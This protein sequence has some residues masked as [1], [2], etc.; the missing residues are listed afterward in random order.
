MKPID[1]KKEYGLLMRKTEAYALLVQQI[2]DKAVSEIA[3]SALA[4]GY[5]GKAW[6]SF[7]DYPETKRL[8]EKLQ[9]RSAKDM[10]AVIVNG[11]TAS[12][13]NSNFKNDKLA[14]QV[15]GKRADQA[16]YERYFDNNEAVLTSFIRRQ[17]NG[18]NLSKRIWKLEEDFKVNLE[19]A[20]SVGMGKGKSAAQLSMDIR[21]YL[22]EPR[23]LF[24]RLRTYDGD[25]NFTGWKLSNPALQYN[26][27]A[28]QYRSSYKNAM[29]LART[30]V[31][32]AYRAADQVRWQQMDFIVGFEVKRSM[33][34]HFHC[35]RCDALAGK[36]PKDFVFT[37]WHPQCMCYIIPILKTAEELDRDEDMIL[38]GLEPSA[39]SAN[40]V[41]DVP[42][43]FKNYVKD[44]SESI[45]GAAERG[46][47]PYFLRDNSY[48]QYL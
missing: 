30:E 25:G 36:Y 26:P 14:R 34:S 28:G 44:H 43:G 17:R 29:R 46:T 33:S 1:H 24:R 21:E 39:D 9:K 10:R 20:L 35:P 6:F 38:Q 5:D 31:N 47:L 41:T 11:I 2:L 40:T 4:E 15:L 48:H 23:K 18:L 13:K 3:A 32:M 7:D 22:Q 12:W 16:K 19:Q 8:F 42:A 37:G 45:A 27:G